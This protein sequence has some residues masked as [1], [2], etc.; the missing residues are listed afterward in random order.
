MTITVVKDGTV[1][2]VCNV[3]AWGNEHWYGGKLGHVCAECRDGD[4]FKSSKQ[5][6][7]AENSRKQ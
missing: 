1:C 5:R 2:T 4:W 6:Q 7:P 3:V